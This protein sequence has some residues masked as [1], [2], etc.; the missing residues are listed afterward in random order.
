MRSLESVGI[1]REPEKLGLSPNDIA[2]HWLNY[3]VHPRAVIGN[4]HEEYS[5]KAVDAI[6]RD[7]E[8]SAHFRG[9]SLEEL[10]VHVDDGYQNLLADAAEKRYQESSR[11]SRIVQGYAE[12]VMN[13]G[14][15][16]G[17]VVGAAVGYYW[18]SQL[19]ANAADYLNHLSHL[20][21]PVAGL[22]EFG[23]FALPEAIIVSAGCMGGMLGSA[24]LGACHDYFRYPL[25]SYAREYAAV[26]KALSPQKE[27]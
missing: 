12:R 14:L 10:S 23:I 25:A 26:S 3:F 5:N 15:W 4:D 6:V 21:A 22:V 20:L 1:I 13:T 11:Q 16:G 17:A 2:S 9:F 24:A 8:K 18:C 7:L 27:K 19:A